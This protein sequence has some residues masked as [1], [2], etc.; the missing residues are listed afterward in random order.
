MFDQAAGHVLP[1]DVEPAAQTDLARLAPLAVFTAHGRV[2][3]HRIPFYPAGGPVTQPGD[4]AG[5]VRAADVR[6]LELET[7]P[8]ATHPEVQMVEG[9]RL[10]GHEHLAGPGCRLGQ[11]PDLENFGTAVLPEERRSHARSV[12]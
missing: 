8:A 3:A 6:H 5:D 11:I 1:Y 9:D 2:H 7:R 12:V 4:A 10:D